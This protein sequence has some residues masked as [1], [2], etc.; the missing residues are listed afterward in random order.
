[1][2]IKALFTYDYGS[3]NMNSIRELG[4]EI[5]TVREE[6]LTYD[7]SIKDIEILACYNPF[8]TLDISSLKKLKW[9]QLSSIGIDQVPAGDIVKTNI[10][11]T[12]NRGGYSIPMGEWVVM[13]I[14]ELMKFSKVMFENQISR[15][16]KVSSK[17]LELYGKTVGFIGTGTIAIESAKRLQAFGVRVY[18][19]NTQGKPAEYFDRCFSRDNMNQMLSM[20]DVVVLAIPS[21]VSTYHMINNESLGVMKKGVFIVN[22]ARGNIVDE[23]ALIEGI[24]CGKI[25]GAA[26]DV[27][28]EEPLPETSPLW[29]LPNVIITPHNSWISEARNERRFNLIYE[30]MRRYANGEKLVNIVDLSKGY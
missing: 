10:M 16:W 28:E 18:G 9:I 11:V 20:C 3:E 22:V 6:G 13:S 8:S 25:G 27:V 1:M 4:Y 7:D 26:L 15:K 23:N 19:M 30:N 21:T 12:N 5:T 14:L 24:K 29:N 2:G 17:V